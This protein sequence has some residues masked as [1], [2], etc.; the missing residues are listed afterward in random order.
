L[1]N[2]PLA[3]WRSQA[4][5]GTAR[6]RPRGLG[7]WRIGI[8]LAERLGRRFVLINLG[9]ER[10]AKKTPGIDALFDTTP[11]RRFRSLAW[12]A[13]LAHVSQDTELPRWLVEFIAERQLDSRWA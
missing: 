12:G 1:D 3:V 6:D 8:E 7:R 9:P 11:S 2:L 5:R 13:L 4:R 10:L